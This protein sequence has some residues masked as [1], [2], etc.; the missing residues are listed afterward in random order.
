MKRVVII[1]A[2]PGG[3]CTGIK[4]KEAGFDSFTIVEQADGVGGT[5]RNNTYPGCRC[6]VPSVLYSFSFAQK[7]DWQSRYA[8]QAE[9][10]AYM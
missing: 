6:D 1:G 7:P 5:W 10:L 4:L 9:I 2:G 3:I 8:P